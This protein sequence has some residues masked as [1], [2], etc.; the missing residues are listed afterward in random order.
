MKPGGKSFL[1]YSTAVSA[2]AAKLSRNVSKKKGL[3]ITDRSKRAI[4]DVVS[5]Y[6]YE[7]GKW[8]MLFEF[9]SSIQSKALPLLMEKT[10]DKLTNLYKNG[11]R[12]KKKLSQS[13]G[14]RVAP[15]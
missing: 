3:N 5:F 1:V 6:N 12:T 14:C 8:E 13:P 11:K 4:F 10:Q 7:T 9:V 15:A 2:D